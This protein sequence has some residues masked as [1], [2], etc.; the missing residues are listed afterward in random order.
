MLN[1]SILY[2]NAEIRAIGV[3]SEQNFETKVKQWDLDYI[4]IS[5]LNF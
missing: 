5:F 2:T 4:S 3:A 1:E